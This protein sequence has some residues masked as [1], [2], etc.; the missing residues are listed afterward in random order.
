MTPLFPETYF[1]GAELTAARAIAV[2][3]LAALEHALTF[4]LINVN[5]EGAGGM[6]LL[7]FAL[8]LRQHGCV[9]TLLRWR[10]DPNRA[11]AVGP[12]QSVQPVALAAG[13]GDPEQLRLLLAHGG[14][15]N[16]R[17]LGEP[18]LL[19]AALVLD[20][21]TLHL[22]AEHK[23]IDLDLARPDGLTPLLLLAYLNQFEQVAYLL[24]RGADFRK[25][26]DSGG[27]VAFT[28]QTRD[29]DPD[30]APHHWQQRVR[31]LLEQRGVQFPV[32]DPSEKWGKKRE[33]EAKLRQQ[34]G[35]TPQGRD[36]ENQVN[37]AVVDEP[38]N[39][40]GTALMEL[41]HA[42]ET[43]YEEWAAAQPAASVSP[44]P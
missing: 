41:R 17:H 35:R 19:R 14:D 36:W 7:L 20:W 1:N 40:D 5:A 16:S 26:D 4:K 11:S 18:A 32:P 30:G 21:P 33:A 27:T 31:Q 24:Q 23:S 28:V 42:A 3:D 25:A 15:P 9:R 44:Q 2:G 10:A 6:T 34:W 13:Y 12:G 22:L 37:Q 38:S 43:A 39:D 29:L 8:S